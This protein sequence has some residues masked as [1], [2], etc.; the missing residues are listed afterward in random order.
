MLIAN[1]RQQFGVDVPRSKA[2][3]ARRK[4]FGAVIG[5]HE[6]QYTRLREYL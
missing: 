1:A 3:R 4:A 6:A 5:D 2:Y